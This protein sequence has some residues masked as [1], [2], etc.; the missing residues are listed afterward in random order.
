[1]LGKVL[2]IKDED[3]DWLAKM[4][5]A[6]GLVDVAQAYKEITHVQQRL[7]TL[8]YHFPGSKARWYGNW[9]KI[10]QNYDTIILFDA[11]LATDLPE[12]IEEHAPQ[13]RLIVYYR[14]P[15]YNNYY[16]SDEAR[17]KCEI[18]S[19][20]QEDCK[21]HD[22]KYNRQ[23]YFYQ[24]AQQ[25]EDPQY[26]SEVFFIGKDKGRL[27]FLRDLDNKLKAAA[28]DAKIYVVPE[29]VIKYNT[30]DKKFLF[31]SRIPYDEVLKYNKNTRCLVEVLQ[32]YQEGLTMRVVE[33]M[34]FGKKLLTNNQQIDTYDFYDP[35]NIYI[36]G[37]DKRDLIEFVRDK[38]PAQWDKKIVAQYSFETWLKNFDDKGAETIK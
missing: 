38:T 4:I 30:E 20:D 24:A 21:Q 27:N 12:Y 33:A 29:R 25:K 36:I 15:W 1:M 3:N 11:F 35:K 13:A 17:K 10:I 9:T 37:K 8:H 7:R 32:K 6:T 23:F 16:L 5:K 18:W 28:I 2:I 26:A 22:L 14:N 19:F 34:F 31:N